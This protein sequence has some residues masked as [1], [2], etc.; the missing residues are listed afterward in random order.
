MVRN[1]SQLRHGRKRLTGR[2]AP[3]SSLISVEET[4][5]ST[6]SGGPGPYVRW[7]EGGREICRTATRRE[8]VPHA[9]SFPCVF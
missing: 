9:V 1:R 6:F 2:P 4:G 3:V 7:S 5:H 8:M